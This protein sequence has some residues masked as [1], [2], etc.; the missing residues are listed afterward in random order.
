MAYIY[1][2][3]N[4]RQYFNRVVQAAQ[5][6]AVAV[7]PPRPC[8]GFAGNYAGMCRIVDKPHMG[9]AISFSVVEQN[10][11]CV[12]TNSGYF[13]PAVMSVGPAQAQA[14]VTQIPGGVAI[15]NTT[16]T[17]YGAGRFGMTGYNYAG[18]FWFTCE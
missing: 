18:K 5:A 16:V 17:V 4:I 8:N 1:I 9:S 2:L 15:Q 6:L 10:N 13:Q 7:Q 12:V 3:E 14:A 11:A